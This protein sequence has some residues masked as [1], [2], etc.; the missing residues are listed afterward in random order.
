MVGDQ[1]SAWAARAGSAVVA[2]SNDDPPGQP[3]HAWWWAQMLGAATAIITLFVAVIY[4]FG[5][6]SLALALWYTKDPVSPELAQVPRDILI[7]RAFSGVIFPAAITALVMVILYESLYLP[8]R[9]YRSPSRPRPPVAEVGTG[10]SNIRSSIAGYVIELG[11]AWHDRRLISSIVL[12][13]LV[14]LAPQVLLAYNYR[15]SNVTQSRL[16]IYVCCFVASFLSIYI[17][18][19]FVPRGWL[20]RARRQAAASSSQRAIKALAS[21]AVTSFALLPA[22]AFTAAAVPLP[23]VVLC[24]SS[25]SHVDEFGRHYEIGNLV[26]TSGQYVYV[27][28]TRFLYYGR[29][30]VEQS[31]NGSYIAAVPLNEA[32][33]ETIG[34]RAECNNLDPALASDPPGSSNGHSASPVET[35]PSFARDYAER[36]VGLCLSKALSP[37]GP[38]I[39]EYVGGGVVR[40]ELGSYEN[41][42]GNP[43][44]N[45]VIDV[46]TYADGYVSGGSTL[47]Y[48]HC[49]RIESPPLTGFYV[50]G[51]AG[52]PHW[53]LLLNPSSTGVISGAIGYF[54]GGSQTAFAQ[55]F[56]GEMNSGLATLT[57]S[58]SGFR[59]AIYNGSSLVLGDCAHWLE[60]VKNDA[61]CTFRPSESPSG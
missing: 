11:R 21:V 31:Y 36:A 50:D 60:F 51:R 61:A 53:F 54:R 42:Q 37:D 4:G 55:T 19:R 43:A 24:G 29:N 9:F 28:E 41:P 35:N 16:V 7:V 34:H 39:D 33:L 17:C 58:G 59:T 15:T 49:Q 52:R 44:D 20:L 27:A 56:T 47:A 6:V 13:G 2:Q 38:L 40:F 57:F 1:P 23:I 14:S 48:W 10:K 3:K 22:V 8:L 5:A 18:L 45:T 46:Q 26:G 32:Q 12:A 25:F 30:S